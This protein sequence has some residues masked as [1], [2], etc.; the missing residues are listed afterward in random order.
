MFCRPHKALMHMKGNS[1][2]NELC[3]PGPEVH[4]RYN[5]IHEHMFVWVFFPAL[6]HKP[7]LPISQRSY[8]Q[9]FLAEK[10]KL[11]DAISCKLTTILNTDSFI[12]SVLPPLSLTTIALTTN[13]LNLYLCTE[14][15]FILRSS[16]L[17]RSYRSVQ[18][19]KIW[20]QKMC[21]AALRLAA[22]PTVWPYLQGMT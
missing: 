3:G 5:H 14:L 7:T 16:V 9:F 19:L 21:F 1:R 22:C 11:W 6:F 2:F 4:C 18:S 12:S 20:V 17:E 13:S 15:P 8:F 10:R